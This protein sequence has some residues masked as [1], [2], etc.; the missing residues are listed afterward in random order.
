MA[1]CA[2]S[3]PVVGRESNDRRP[4]PAEEAATLRHLADEL[5][6]EASALAVKSQQ[7]RDRAGLLSRLADTME[8]AQ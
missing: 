3:T 8:A 6:L 1:N 4:T 5:R 7:R 2:L